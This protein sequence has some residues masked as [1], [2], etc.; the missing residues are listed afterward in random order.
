MAMTV[1]PGR[2][3]LLFR[4]AKSAWPDV[5]DHERPLARRG[6]RD[7]PAMGRWLRDAGYRPDQVL[8]STARRARETWQLTQPALGA[9]PPAVF[10][11]RVYQAPAA[12]LL[13][14]IRQAP[15]AARTLLVLG[16]DPGIPELAIMLAAAAPPGHA[17]AGTTAG[18]SPMLES[19]RAK[20]PTAALAV[21]E[22]TGS[23]DQL[24]PGLTRLVRFITPSQLA[25]PADPGAAASRPGEVA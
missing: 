14:L 16:H 25:P 22:C 4:H 9:A 17:D 6:Q 2:T 19:M 24:G 13:G 1:H 23:W 3:L 18:P 15:I 8:C 5:P 11:A 20:F 10:D 21:F 12:R 7:A